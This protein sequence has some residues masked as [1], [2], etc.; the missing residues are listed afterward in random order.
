M[1]VFRSLGFYFKPVLRVWAGIPSCPVCHVSHVICHVSH[2]TYHFFSSFFGTKWWSLLWRVCHQR[3][4]PRLVFIQRG[5]QNMTCRGVVGDHYCVTI[6]MI[7][8]IILVDRHCLNTTRGNITFSKCCNICR[9]IGVIWMFIIQLGFPEVAYIF[10]S[11][12]SIPPTLYIQIAG[13]FDIFWNQDNISTTY[14]IWAIW[15]YNW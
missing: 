7:C 8:V 3:G 6:Y 11:I 14:L 4:L 12:H 2:V 10:C 1:I 9:R 5:S 15:I 13:F